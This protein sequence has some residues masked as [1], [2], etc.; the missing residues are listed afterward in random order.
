[1]YVNTINYWDRITLKINQ[2]VLARQEHIFYQEL[3]LVLNKPETILF[4]H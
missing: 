4:T 3:T 1:M 2:G